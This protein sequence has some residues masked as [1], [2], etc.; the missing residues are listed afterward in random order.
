MKFLSKL[1]SD[2]IVVG[3][4][5]VIISTCSF[6]L[7]ANFTK[8]IE[9]GNVKKIGTITYKRKVAQRKYSGQ[10]V[11]EDIEQNNP[12][13]SNDS[14]RTSS[15]SEAGSRPSGD[16]GPT[17]EH[18]LGAEELLELG[19]QRRARIHAVL[20]TDTQDLLPGVGL[21]VDVHGGRPGMIGEDVL[22]S[23]HDRG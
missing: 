19:E 11:W 9:V 12:V 17:L 3:M 15:I 13:Y 10:V 18:A 16:R 1:G 21:H 14:I 23:P 2:F 8:K 6:F 22:E 4:S 5:F 20:G 7:Y